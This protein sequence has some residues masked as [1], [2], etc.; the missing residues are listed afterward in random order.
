MKLTKSNYKGWLNVLQYLA[1]YYRVNFSIEN[2]QLFI[3]NTLGTKSFVLLETITNKIGF[4]VYH[5]KAVVDSITPSRLPLVV[6]FDDGQV[7][8]VTKMDDKDGFAILFGGDGHVETT[9]V[10]EFIKEHAV[11]CI[12]L[13]PTNNIKDVRVDS[14]IRPYEK[15]WFWKIVL[16][17][18]RRYID[19]MVASV[20]ANLLALSG[21]IFSMQIY[22]RVVPAQSETT[23]WVLFLGVMI[24]VFFEFTMRMLR[25]YISDVI[26]KRADLRISD[27]VFSR[28]LRIR[29]D[30]RPKSTGTFIS[31][32]REL[33]SVRELITSTT[34]ATL[35]DLPFFLMFVFI[36]WFIG[37]P[38][39]YVVLCAVPLI[40]IP[41]LIAQIPL[42]KLS[43]EGMRESAI[44]N[45]TLIE[46]VQGIDDI[47]SLR[48]EARFQNQW[49][50]SCS[51]SATVSMKQRLVTNFLVIWT[52][53]LQT[54]VYVFVLLCGAYLV[55]KGD[56]TTGVLVGASIL[57]SRTVAP[58]AQVTGVLSR[59]QSA[60]VALKGLNDL[61]EKPIDQPEDCKLIHLNSI[62]GDFELQ[63]VAVIYDEESGVN[64]LNI[65][66]LKIFPGEK[67]AIL[68]R[69]GSGKST[70]LRVL[71][72]L[73]KP[74]SGRVLLD[75]LDLSLIDPSDVRRDI[76]LLEQYARLFFGSIRDN[77]I[78]GCPMA[79]DADIQRALKLSGAE[80]FVSKQKEG[81]NH[82]IHEGGAGLSGGE[83]QSLLLAR[84]L[85]CD[86]KVLLLD[87][88]TSVLDEVSERNFITK[89]ASWMTEKTLIVATHRLPILSVVDRIIVLDNGKIVM[90]GPRNHILKEL[91]STHLPQK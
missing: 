64:S 78:L 53:E 42:A 52:Q 30:A 23:L 68:G 62:D 40:I 7:G 81:L 55:I 45:A 4:D 69:N 12:V 60:K 83:R 19:I 13:R 75:K 38:L 33:E 66:S 6:T 76:G 43:K 88:P 21:M 89:M 9:I 59:W 41:G 25:A 1:T 11:G 5:A 90:D 14:Y 49:N 77:I 24:A 74:Q 72:G 34:F 31:Q 82:L 71:S 32:I 58:L 56:I 8:V 86:H 20:L 2:T 70:L 80:L 15:N 17:D 48:A 57:S 22:D 26:G 3:E 46:S 91:Q 67:V 16:S 28:A 50:H 65:P 18:W 54:M 35:A 47:K 29:C 85:I 79:T 61:M 36:L 87:E 51:V 44:R 63:N 84:H 27:H 37:G 39:A 10:K 73:S